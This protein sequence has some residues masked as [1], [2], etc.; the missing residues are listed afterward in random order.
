MTESPPPKHRA[1]A[2]LPSRR[3]R[4]KPREV[5]MLLYLLL[6]GGVIAWKYIPRAWHP[7][8]TLETPHHRISST[9][10]RRQ[11]E[12][13]ARALSLLYDA[14]SNR[15]GMLP[16]FQR[17][18]PR[19]K[20]QLFKDRA[21]FRRVNPNLGWAEAF[22]REP[23]CRA[24]FSESEGNPYHWMLHES[25][26]QLNRE[27]ARL[28]LAKWLEEGLAVYFSTSR[29]ERDKLVVSRVDPNT[30]PVWW[31]YELAT[32]PDLPENLRNGSVIPLRAIIM[33][34]GGPDLNREFNLY[35]LHWW[36]L[37]RFIFESPKYRERALELMERGGGIEAFERIIG[38]VEQVE[39]E[40]HAYVRQLK[41]AL[42]A[43]HLEPR[44][45]A[46]GQEAA[47]I[48]AHKEASRASRWPNRTIALPVTA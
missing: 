18:H 40:W 39:A 25:V 27:V 12:E 16:Q 3:W 46:R 5:R 14:Y 1:R 4:L 19:V 22:Y 41:S 28:K 9:A 20:V 45:N 32:Q 11:T 17:E 21:E 2:E 29:L 37:T 15:L 44:K 33:N 47:W 38:P 23:Y 34:R 30:Y 6:L 24:Y 43:E 26:H 13:T 35:Y 8:L 48:N 36:T 42:A 31:L 10:S 7:T